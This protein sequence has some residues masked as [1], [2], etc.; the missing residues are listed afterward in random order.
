MSLIWTDFV[1]TWKQWNRVRRSTPPSGSY[2]ISR[3]DYSLIANLSANATW[4]LPTPVGAG[5]VLKIKNKS[6]YELTLSGTI[7]LYEAVTSLVL[8]QGDMVT[9]SDDGTHW[10][11]GD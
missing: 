7:Y 6:A 3:D 9:L 10:S 2:T 8:V 1:W 11:V 5:Q 4:T